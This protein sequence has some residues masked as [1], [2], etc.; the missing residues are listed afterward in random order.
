[1]TLTSKLTVA[2]QAD[3]A[4]AL[5]LAAAQVPLGFKKQIDLTTGTGAGQADRI[6]HDTRE[7]AASASEDL[8]LAG[9]LVDAL[10]ASLTFARVKGL[11]V[12]AE[13]T[14]VNNVVVG[15]AAANQ[16][17]GP[18][19]AAAHT[20]AVRPNGVLALF[21]SDGVG[22]VVTAATGDLFKIAN[23]GAGTPV[24]YSI[25]IIGASA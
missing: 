16:F 14:N 21:A 23:S 24:K 25:V 22:Y 15:G 6:F 2:A 18:F 9:G 17:V 5:D 3:L 20:L 10:G 12:A 19:G 11:I 13:P 8:D 7:L 1:M 4:N